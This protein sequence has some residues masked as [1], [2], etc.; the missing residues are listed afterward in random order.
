MGRI[1]NRKFAGFQYYKL[2]RYINKAALVGIKV[3]EVLEHGHHNIARL[4]VK[5][6]R[7]ITIVST[8]DLR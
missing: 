8:S 2:A 5:N 6:R 7:N 1:F 3:I 4:V